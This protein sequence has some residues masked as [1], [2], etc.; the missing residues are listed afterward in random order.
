MRIPLLLSDIVVLG[1]TI[2]IS[3][4]VGSITEC[5]SS[6]VWLMSVNADSACSRQLKLV[7]FTGRRGASSYD[8]LFVTKHL[9]VHRQRVSISI[10]LLLYS[11]RPIK[12]QFVALYCNS[13]QIATSSYINTVGSI[14]QLH[15]PDVYNTIH[16]SLSLNLNIGTISWQPQAQIL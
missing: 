13:S 8:P 15:F 14:L 4:A 5:L 3:G 12:D 11:I 9:A 1:D 10:C 6:Q 2:V 16:I 7:T